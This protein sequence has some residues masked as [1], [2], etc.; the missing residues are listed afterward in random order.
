MEI[1]A[2]Q[3]MSTIRHTLS[4]Q[5]TIADAVHCFRQA[6]REDGKPVFG[7]L[8]ID[9][10]QRLAGMLSMYDILLFIRPKHIGV[11]GEMQD[12]HMEGLYENLLQRTR[13]VH[14]GDL[15]SRDVVSISPDTHILVI[16]D[17]MLKRHIRRLPVLEGEK[18]LGMVYLSAVFHHVLEDI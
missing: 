4:P 13:S 5:D 9:K 1:T 8:V 7:L 11:W 14:V 15:M 18:I 16:I 17:L 2:S 12:L 3:V 6:G 10:S